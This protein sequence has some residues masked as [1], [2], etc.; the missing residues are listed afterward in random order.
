MRFNTIGH[1]DKP[2]RL[3]AHSE[4]YRIKLVEKPGIR[5]HGFHNGLLAVG[6]NNRNPNDRRDESSKYVHVYQASDL[7][8]DSTATWILEFCGDVNNPYDYYIKLYD[9]HDTSVMGGYLTQSALDGQDKRDDSPSAFVHLY[10]PMSEE[11]IVRWLVIPTEDGNYK[12]VFKNERG[13]IRNPDPSRK[14]LLCLH[15]WWGNPHPSPFEGGRC[16]KRDDQSA[17]AHVRIEDTQ[18][19]GST[20]SLEVTNWNAIL[21]AVHKEEEVEEP[22]L[23]PP[24]DEQLVLV[25]HLE[26]KANY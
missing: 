4:I 16:D 19:Q 1:P 9:P 18:L 14:L 6:T 22:P 10:Y 20:W 8:L 2:F 5:R 13:T 7:G 15:N 17:Y 21:S 23:E 3:G 12:I 24:A 25:A 26:Q 11:S